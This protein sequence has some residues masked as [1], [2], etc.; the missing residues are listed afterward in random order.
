MTDVTN[1]GEYYDFINNNIMKNPYV[2][3]AIAL[4]FV[5]YVFFIRHLGERTSSLD[6]TMGEKESISYTILKIIVAFLILIIIIFTVLQYIYDVDIKV[7]LKNIFGKMPI[8]DIDILN[9]LGKNI[10]HKGDVLIENEANIIGE[11]LGMVEK[12]LEQP[13]VFN[14]QDNVYTY[15]DAK[16]V[17]KAYDAKLA[18]YNQIE[19]A[20]NEGGEW[21]SYGWSSE[22][23]ILY[24]TQKQTYDKLQK[25]KGHEHDC[26][27]PGINGGYIGNKKAKFGVNCYGIKPPITRKEKILMERNNI[28][29]ESKKDRCDKK[30]VNNLKKYLKDIAISPFSKDTWNN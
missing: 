2:F 29:P 14:I 24:P 20:Y 30:K 6:V 27:R 17:C 4:V 19:K 25:T 21:C 11:E 7:G 8:I 26:G 1:T 3:L 13:E 18:T 15:D 16:A 10:L 5:F 12:S 22:Q 9:N 28:Y 23:M